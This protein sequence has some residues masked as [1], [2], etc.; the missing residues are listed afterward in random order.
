MLLNLKSDVDKL[1]NLKYN[2]MSRPEVTIDKPKTKKTPGFPRGFR[3]TPNCEP[4][5]V[6]CP[7]VSKEYIEEIMTVNK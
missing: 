4:A 7:E 6:D 1:N 3:L 2:K 5:P